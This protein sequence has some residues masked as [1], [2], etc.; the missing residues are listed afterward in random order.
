MSAPAL[1]LDHCNPF[2]QEEED[3]QVPLDEDPAPLSSQRDGVNKA[4]HS[5]NSDPEHFHHT[6]CV[7]G[8]PYEPVSPDFLHVLLVLFASCI[9]LK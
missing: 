1:L 6:R 5:S 8:P 2:V 3:E 4:T 9:S 7:P